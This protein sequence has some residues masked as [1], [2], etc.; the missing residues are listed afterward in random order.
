[1]IGWIRE[2]FSLNVWAPY[3]TQWCFD[4]KLIGLNVDTYHARNVTG[5]Y[6][7]VEA[8]LVGFGATLAWW[9]DGKSQGRAQQ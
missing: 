8:W 7:A 1:M 9:P 4:V 3:I 5:R 6:F 2:H